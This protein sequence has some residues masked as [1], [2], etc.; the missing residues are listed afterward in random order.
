VRAGARRP[1]TRRLALTAGPHAGQSGSARQR[2]GWRQDQADD[3]SY[4]A[5]SS[6]SRRSCCGSREY[7]APQRHQVDTLRNQIT[8]SGSAGL[9]RNTALIHIRPPP[10]DP[11]MNSD[12]LSTNPG[13]APRPTPAWPG[14]RQLTIPDELRTRPLD[15]RRPGPGPATDEPDELRIQPSDCRLPAAWD[16]PEGFSATSMGPPGCQLWD[17]PACHA[18]GLDHWPLRMPSSRSTWG[19][20]G[21]R[22]GRLP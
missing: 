2:P 20:G 13:P 6:S 1:V 4:S 19:F 5:S 8:P 9:R 11:P 10:D 3:R 15:E 17:R 21:W 14:T 16:H 7:D 22:S 12:R 18:G